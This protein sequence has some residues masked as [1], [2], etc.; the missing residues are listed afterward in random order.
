[1][2]IKR[3][4]DLTLSLIFI[5]IFTPLFFMIFIIILIEIKGSAFHYSKRIGKNNKIFKMIKFKTMKDNTP[6]VATHLLENPGEYIT[7]SGKFLRRTSLDELPQL[8]SIFSGKMSFVGP[9]PA[10]YNQQ[11]L[12]NLRNKKNIHSLNEVNSTR[13]LR[14]FGPSKMSLF[15][16]TIHSFSIIAVFKYTVFLRSTFMIFFLFFFTKSFG[17]IISLTQILII[18]FNLLIFIISNRESEIALKKSNENIININEVT[19]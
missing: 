5:L 19:H 2:K 6:D 12:I 10:L 17:Q 7:K 4:F 16:L 3:F 11:D 14:Y 1:M 9:R 8:F 15:N 13:G 18:F